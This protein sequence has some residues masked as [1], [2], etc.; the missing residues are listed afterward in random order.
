MVSVLAYLA[1]D[2]TGAWGALHIL[3]AAR[4]TRGFEPITPANRY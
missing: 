4:V 1:A 2:V 3:P